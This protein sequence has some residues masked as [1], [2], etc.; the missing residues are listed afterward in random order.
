MDPAASAMAN[1]VKSAGVYK[2]PSDTMQKTG[3]RSRSLAM[4]GALAG[5]AGSGPV[6]QGHNPPDH[7]YYGSGANGAG[8]PARKMNHLQTP[9]VSDVFVFLDEHADSINDG[10]FMHDP[11][12]PQGA[13]HWRDLPASY[14]RGAGS[15]SFADGHSEIH[16]WSGMQ[17]GPGSY[18]VLM[19]GTL[20]WKTPTLSFHRD[21]EWLQDRMPYAK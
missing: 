15:F 9:G 3:T 14:H 12:Y 8:G 13:E 18:P 1:Y 5:R 20:P 6:V 4:N 19:D 2:C 10:T 21:Y 11:G 7:S 17:F 16:K